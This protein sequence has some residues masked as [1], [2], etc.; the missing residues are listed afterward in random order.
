MIGMVLKEV[1]EKNKLKLEELAEKAKIPSKLLED[2]EKGKKTISDK[3]LDKLIEALGITH[4]D[5]FSSS[6]NW[7]ENYVQKIGEKIRALREKN[8][9]K[10]SQLG[11]KARISLTNLSEIER[12]KLSP[13]VENIRKIANALNVPISLLLTESRNSDLVAE[14]IKIARKARGITQKELAV[15]AGISPGMVGQLEMG[16]VNA[17]FKIMKKISEVLGVSICYLIL[18]QSE[19]DEII[20]GLSPQLRNMLYEPKVQLLIG[21]ICT[22]DEAHLKLVLNFIDML[23]NPVLPN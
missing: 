7:E 3:T 8:N 6:P 15:R 22:M 1:R 23:K 18:E 10:L 21:S 19:V 5:L 14:K 9:L 16:K 4:D 2:I 17:S 12:G 11:N 13:P 20:G